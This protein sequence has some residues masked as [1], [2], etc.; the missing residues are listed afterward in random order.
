MGRKQRQYRNVKEQL[1]TPPIQCHVH[2]KPNRNSTTRSPFSAIQSS[3]QDQKP[4]PKR[5]RL[6]ATVERPFILRYTIQKER[7]MMLGKRR[8]LVVIQRRPWRLLVLELGINKTSIVGK[9]QNRRLC[10]MNPR[11][12][13]LR[14]RRLKRL[15][16]SSKLVISSSLILLLIYMT[17]KKC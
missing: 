6:R 16:V 7:K 1:M 14:R 3:K 9:K 2:S 12:D 13:N 10:L 11:N 5:S 17:T 4:S 8:I 15:K